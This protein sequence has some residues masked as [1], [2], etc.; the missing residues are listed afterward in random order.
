MLSSCLVFVLLFAQSLETASDELQAQV[1]RVITK[2]SDSPVSGLWTHARELAALGDDAVPAISEGL[3][4]ASAQVRLGCA[5]ALFDLN[6]MEKA[7]PVLREI[8]DSRAAA[9]LRS[10]ALFLLRDSLEA[11]LG[12]VVKRIA[13]SDPEPLIRIDAARTLWEIEGGQTSRVILER[14]LRSS[15]PALRNRAAVALGEIG[16]VAGQTKTILVSLSGEPN[17]LGHRASLIL[18]IERLAREASASGNPFNLSTE[19]L[20]KEKDKKIKELERQRDIALAKRSADGGN[21]KQAEPLLAWL[22]QCI[23]MAYVDPERV[24]KG[25][26]GEFLVGAAKGMVGVLDRFS[27][28]MDVEET[29]LFNEGIRGSYTGVGAQISF[30]KETGLLEIVR[31]LFHGPADQAGLQPH[32]KVVK[33]DG[34]S[35]KGRKMDELV[36]MLKGLKGSTVELEILRKG[37]EEPRTFK[38]VRDE[39]KVASVHWRML[40]G[41]IAYVRLDHFGEQAYTE[42]TKAL[43]E[44]LYL[45]MKGIILDLRRNPGGLLSAAVKIVDLFVTEE[46]RPIVT[47]KGPVGVKEERARDVEP[48]YLTEPLVILVN[49]SSASAS[50]IVSGA[51]QDFDHRATLVGTSTYGKGSV[52]RVFGVP[53]K[54]AIPEL[55]GNAALRLTVQHY[56]L[57]SGRCIH[58]K[59]DNEGRIIEKGGVSPD[60]VVEDRDFSLWKTKEFE[61]LRDHEEFVQYVEKREK[62]FAEAEKG[63][64]YKKLLADGDGGD[65][66]KYPEAGAFFSA[67]ADEIKLD[68]DEVRYF[69]RTVLR[70]RYED[71]IGRQLACDFQD[72]LQL[73]RAIREMIKRLSIKREDVPVYDFLTESKVEDQKGGK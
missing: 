63:G 2:L 36:H 62:E 37:W 29:R 12:P 54:I 72:D 41:S 19:S 15:D 33:I 20:L 53:E 71:H 73:Q 31:P 9:A 50:E 48:Q 44:L 38:I 22:K 10:A 56:Y 67:I 40:P 21:G 8:A 42:V 24:E 1:E 11:G 13:E 28:F 58:S 49:G 7:E 5:K 52:Q 55:G 16:Y 23:N 35:V 57:P 18:Q 64:F 60:I 26:K 46:N 69:I 66:S 70:R 30:D 14:F 59:R 27:A 45:D 39:V 6:E 47:Q 61:K 25:N 51:L 65:L 4:S 32:D 3:K 17:P 68:R 43:D 34:V